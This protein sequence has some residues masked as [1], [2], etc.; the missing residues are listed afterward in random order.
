[1]GKKLDYNFIR[2]FFWFLKNILFTIS[3]LI[4]LIEIWILYFIIFHVQKLFLVLD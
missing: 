4:V 1:M 2:V 3:A